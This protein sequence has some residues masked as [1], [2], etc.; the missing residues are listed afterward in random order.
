M[1][2]QWKTQ[3]SLFLKPSLS[4][5]GY[6]AWLGLTMTAWQITRPLSALA[7]GA[8]F[9]IPAPFS[10]FTSPAPLERP[11][12]R[13]EQEEEKGRWYQTRQELA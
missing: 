13:Q 4:P 11:F 3:A 2:Q 1:E 8:G 10:L 7:F 9:I 5:S 12:H 6:R